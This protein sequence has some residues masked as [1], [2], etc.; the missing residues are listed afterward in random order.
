MND[1]PRMPRPTALARLRRRALDL[2]GH[3]AE[4]APVSPSAWAES[5]CDDRYFHRVLAASAVH[6]ATLPRN[7]SRRRDLPRQRDPWGFS[8]YDVPERRIDPRGVA[9]LPECRIVPYRNRWGNEFHALLT[10]DGRALK[11]RGTGP[12]RSE[13]LY[14]VEAGPPVDCGEVAWILGRW[15]RNYYHWLVYHLPQV[16]MLQAL[17]QSDRMLIPRDGRLSAVIGDSLAALGVDANEVRPVPTGALRVDPLWVVESDR[18]DPGLLR[19]LRA[20]IAVPGGPPT[21]RVC[22]SRELAKKRRLADGGN[23]F[24]FLESAAFEVVQAERL[25]FREQAALASETGILVGVHGA[26]LANMVFMPEGSHVVELAHPRYPS[27]Q[28]YAL[29]AALGLGYWLLW[30]TPADE[31][32]SA[33]LDVRIETRALERVVAAIEEQG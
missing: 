30:G 21:R 12:P 19:A 22:L 7:V 18:F 15:H 1:S 2:V 31:R 28:F 33:A 20:R 24:G 29:A 11:L 14:A 3:A 27:P 13:E 26:G 8:F 10:R 23:A 5:A 9:R 4:E 25:T 6:R 16:M 17:G 32:G